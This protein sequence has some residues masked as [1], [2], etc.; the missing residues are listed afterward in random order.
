MNGK[1][2]VFIPLRS[3]IPHTFALPYRPSSKNHMSPLLPKKH[4]D[5]TLN[6]QCLPRHSSK[7]RFLRCECTPRKHSHFERREKTYMDRVAKMHTRVF[8]LVPTQKTYRDA[9]SLI[10]Q[11]MLLWYMAC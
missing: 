7:T 2:Y 3:R 11:N 8:L 4:H 5:K 1:L 6:P 10:L 9:F